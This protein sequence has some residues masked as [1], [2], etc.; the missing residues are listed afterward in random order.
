MPESLQSNASPSDQLEGDVHAV[1]VGRATIMDWLKALYAFSSP[2]LAFCDHLS[3]RAKCHVRLAWLRKRLLCR[4]FLRYM[5]QP[6]RIRFTAP[7]CFD[8]NIYVRVFLQGLLRT[9]ANK[10]V[11]DRQTKF[12]N[13]PFITGLSVR[14]I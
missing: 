8:T 14:L 7:S 12:V 6:I 1:N 13:K 3:L 11:T 10:A 9:Y 5:L 4:L 2:C